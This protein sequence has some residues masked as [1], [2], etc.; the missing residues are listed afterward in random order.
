MCNGSVKAKGEPRIVDR[1]G[2]RQLPIGIESFEDVLRGFSY[3]DKSLAVVDLVDRRG[4]TLYCRPRRFGKS[5]FLR[6]LQC[7]FE[8]LKVARAGNRISDI[9]IAVQEY[10]ESNGFGVVRD[11]VGHGV[12]RHQ[13]EHFRQRRWHSGSLDHG[14]GRL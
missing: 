6:M 4:V 2:R 11:Y 14:N 13:T 1:S 12:G 5:T 9:G 8:A 10:A 7:F 3:V